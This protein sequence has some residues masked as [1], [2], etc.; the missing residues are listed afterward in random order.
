[1][2]PGSKII[3]E[4]HYHAVGEE[5]TDQ[6]ELGIYLY[7]KGQEPKYR[8]V[9]A[10]LSSI[11]GGARNI[12]IPP[13]GTFVSQN[14]HVMRQAG[15]V[16]NFQPHMHLR[17]KAMSMEAILPNGTTQ[18]LSH[19]NNFNFNWHNNY[20]YADD[21]APLLPK[22]TILK[23]T[24]WYDNT[25]A[26]K[27]NPDPESVGRLGRSHR[28][29]DGP[30]VGEHHLHERRGIQGRTRTAQAG[31]ELRGR[32]VAHW[33]RE[34]MRARRVLLASVLADRVLGCRRPRSE[35]RRACQSSRSRNR[36][37]ASP[38]RSRAGIRTPTARTRLLV[39][40]FNRN[41][42][43]TLDI[44]VG[45]NN[46]IEP[47]GPDL[48]QPTHFLPRRQWGVFTIVVPKDFGKNKLT[49]TIVANGQTTTVPMHLDPLWIVAPFKDVALGNTP[50]VLRLDS[51]GQTY[52]G[53]PK[54]LAATYTASVASP[55]TLNVWTTDDGIRAP[56]ARRPAR[57]VTRS[58]EQVP[59][60]RRGELQQR[61]AVR[62]R[63]DGAVH[64]HRVLLSGRRVPAARAGQRR[65]G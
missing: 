29:R 5:I 46:R 26:N 8:Q 59:R 30:R 21:A 15:R 10:S 39:G 62:G 18:M 40:Y 44:P 51:N 34:R 41:A 54:G 23:I 24:S 61:C 22:G 52:T 58:V 11:A 45:P 57:L 14:F 55:L 53:P 32:A 48:G 28:G 43:Q 9:L 6:V 2:L 47:G 13:N 19:V 36:A 25:T 27:N 42:K 35:C 63:E 56:E 65:D 49:W 20:V 60:S 4:V 16:E 38:A 31:P 7:P 33:D 50:P 64:D 17:G 3:F 1:M 37:R 12:D